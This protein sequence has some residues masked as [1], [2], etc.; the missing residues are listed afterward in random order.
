[1][2]TPILLAGV[3]L[4]AGFTYDEPHHAKAADAASDAAH[5]A[6]HAVVHGPES[7]SALERLIQGNK[8]FVSGDVERPRQDAA[9]RLELAGGQHPFAIVVT[10]SD[11]RLCPEFIFDQGLGDLFVIRVAG[12]TLDNVALGSIEYAVHHLHSR[13]VVVMGHEKCGAVSAAVAGGKLSGH[14]PHVVKPITPA[15]EKSKAAGSDALEFAIKENVRNMVRLLSEKSEPTAS[16]V[17]SG[18]LQVAGMRYD[19]DSGEAS[20]VMFL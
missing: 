6:P 19:L 14:L 20:L 7:Q 10:C 5:A 13:L 9:T 11:S 2:R 12:N 1:M 15:A 17:S 18:E 4:T 8:R 16:L 3:L